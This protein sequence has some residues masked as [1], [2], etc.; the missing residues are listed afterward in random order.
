MTLKGNNETES[1]LQRTGK[2]V[3]MHVDMTVVS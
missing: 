2:R 3:L 1:A